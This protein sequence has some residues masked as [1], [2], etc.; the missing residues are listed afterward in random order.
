MS[1]TRERRTF[2][3]EQ[4]RHFAAN[5]IEELEFIASTRF[6][7]LNLS[8]EEADVVENEKYAIADRIW[9]ACRS[10]SPQPRATPPSPSPSTP[11]PRKDEI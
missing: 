2:L 4:A 3:K 6:D 11:S 9:K 8:E 1:I 7:D 5:V 10:P